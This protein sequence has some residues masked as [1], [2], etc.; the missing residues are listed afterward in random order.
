MEEEKVIIA[1]A[2]Q[3]G[4]A[5]KTTIAYHLARLAAQAGR[6]VL[7]VDVDPQGNMTELLTEGDVADANH[8]K[9]IFDEKNPVPMAVVDNI[10]L[11]G[12]D[13]TLSA[14]ENKLNWRNIGLLRL[15]LNDRPER[16]VIIDCPPNL[17]LM[18]SSALFCATRL[19]VPVTMGRSS[20][21]G[22]RDLFATAKDLRDMGKDVTVEPLGIVLNSMATGQLRAREARDLLWQGYATL[23]LKTTIPQAASVEMAMN[24]KKAVWEIEPRGK[25][26]AAF[27]E[28]YAE[29][30]GRLLWV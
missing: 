4:G 26:A 29:I 27:R 7:V 25:A 13:I 24:H 23:M 16:L 14:Y 11:I 30:A 15:Y 28:L 10:R 5:G 20:V 12:S 8:T 21:K 1:V 2:N 9:L 3:K 18:T 6:S 19:L 17:G 22:L